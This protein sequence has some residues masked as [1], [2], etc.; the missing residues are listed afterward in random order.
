MIR[1]FNHQEAKETVR[2]LFKERLAAIRANGIGKILTG[3]FVVI[4]SASTFVFFVRIG[5]ISIWL[6]GSLAMACVYGLW[7]ILLGVLKVLAPKSERGD[8]ADND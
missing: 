3:I 6:L 5:F 1:G 2:V 7:M 4:G 8:A